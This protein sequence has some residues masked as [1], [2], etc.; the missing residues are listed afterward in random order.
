MTRIK[1]KA[2][3]ELIEK[4]GKILGHVLKQLRKAAQEGVTPREIDSLAKK[5][6]EN[7]GAK[8][9]FLGYLPNGATTPF[10]ATICSSVNDVIVHGTPNDTPLKNGDIFSIDCGVIF[11]GF[12]ADAA[13]TIIIGNKP[14]EVAHSR[15]VQVTK[16]ALALGVAAAQVGNTIGDIGHAI[17]THVQSNGF[18]IVRGGL[19]GH[20][21]GKDLHED[22]IIFNEGEPGKG[23]KIKVGMALA[24]EPMVA[25]GSHEIIQTEDDGYATEDGSFAAHFEHTILILEDGPKIVTEN[26]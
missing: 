20:G 25:I 13:T 9:G 5:L 26:E 18:K 23:E 4:A 3:L 17:A 19:T 15:L 11:Q 14:K 8:P 22:P 1:S 21:I 6:I 7:A 12:N 2:E 10:P 16:E 24:I